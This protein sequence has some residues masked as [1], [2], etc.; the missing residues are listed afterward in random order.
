MADLLV[1]PHRGCSPDS[2]DIF[3][4]GRIRHSHLKLPLKPG[5]GTGSNSSGTPTVAVEWHR[6]ECGGL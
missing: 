4:G 2:Q 3:P 1:T 6:Q 5:S